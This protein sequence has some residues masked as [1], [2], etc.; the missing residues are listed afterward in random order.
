MHCS[1]LL[2]VR[3]MMA[4]DP[5][6]IGTDH[7]QSDSTLI[8][9]RRAEPIGREV[10]LKGSQPGRSPASASFV[11]LQLTADHAFDS[12]HIRSSPPRIERVRNREFE[13]LGDESVPGANGLVSL[14]HIGREFVKSERHPS[15]PQ[16]LQF[17]IFTDYLPDFATSRIFQP[18]VV[19]WANENFSLSG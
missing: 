12:H 3:T 16:H 1:A 9:Q 4:R 11:F 18:F 19:L 13:I 2:H 7:H 8:G 15:P 10:C 5:T 17:L 14:P 6:L